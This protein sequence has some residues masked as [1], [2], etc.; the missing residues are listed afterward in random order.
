MAHLYPQTLDLHSHKSQSLVAI[1]D[2]SVGQSVCPRVETALG[3]VT[4]YHFL[5]EGGCLNTGICLC[6]SSSLTRGRVCSL[7]CTQ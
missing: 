5:S 4:R 2:R 3:L 6:G 7:Q 1:D